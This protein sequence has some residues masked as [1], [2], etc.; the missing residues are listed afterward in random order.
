MND[1]S[2]S[3]D[4]KIKDDGTALPG[5]PSTKIRISLNDLE[6]EQ[7][8]SVHMVNATKKMVAC[9]KFKYVNKLEMIPIKIAHKK[10]P[11]LLIKYYENRI[12][13]RENGALTK[14]AL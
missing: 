6:V 4:D 2:D 10:C 9:V 8:K 1:S 7:V 5:E 13:W 14:N 11:Q 3:G 12:Y